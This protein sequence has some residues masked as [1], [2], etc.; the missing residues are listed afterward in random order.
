[1]S[2]VLERLDL[3][4][5]E[6]TSCDICFAKS[7]AP[8]AT[9]RQGRLGNKKWNNNRSRIQKI[10]SMSAI[11]Q[12]YNTVWPNVILNLCKPVGVKSNQE[13]NHKEI[14]LPKTKQLDLTWTWLREKTL[15]STIV[16]CILKVASFV[17]A[18]ICCQIC[19]KMSVSFFVRCLKIKSEEG[20]GYIYI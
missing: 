4:F 20:P 1:M 5:R 18:H 8:N 10:A 15:A 2:C 7:K 9:K 17:C 11:K 14:L 13:Q 16:Q 12:L 19:F 3:Q 6:H